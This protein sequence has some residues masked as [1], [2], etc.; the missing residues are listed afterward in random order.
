MAAEDK[1]YCDPVRTQECM[2]SAQKELAHQSYRNSKLLHVQE[3]GRYF[4]QQQPHPHRSSLE[5]T[6]SIC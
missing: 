1:N 2:Y 6:P 3:T 5:V 4:P